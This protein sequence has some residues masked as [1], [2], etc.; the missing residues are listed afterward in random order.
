MEKAGIP[1]PHDPSSRGK[2]RAQPSTKHEPCQRAT[3]K[4]R[5]SPVV[6]G[7]R[8]TPRGRLWS[9]KLQTSTRTKQRVTLC[10]PSWS[11]AVGGLGFQFWSFAGVWRLKSGVS[12]GL[13][14]FVGRSPSVRAL[15][16]EQGSLYPALH[17]LIKRGWITFDEGTSG[18]Q[19]PREVLPSDRQGPQAAPDRN[20]QVGRADSSNRAHPPSRLSGVIP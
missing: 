16:D 7:S 14:F 3:S 9:L 18:E 11:G 5:H 6:R 17:R 8:G 4:F 10:L 13:R 12:S 15:T 1:G 19:P 20:E 2:R